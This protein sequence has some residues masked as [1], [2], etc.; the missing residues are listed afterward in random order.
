MLAGLALSAVRSLR[1][2]RVLPPGR[3]RG[4]AVLVLLLLAVL[5]PLPASFVFAADAA[6]ILEGAGEPTLLG[7]AVILTATQLALLLVAWLF[8]LRPGALPGV[9]PLPA[10]PWLPRLGRGLLL[11]VPVWL[12]ATTVGALVALV[13]MQLG[14][15]PEPQAV[16]EAIG[17]VHP[18]IVIGSYLVLTPVAEE[19]FFRGVVLNA[20]G[21]EYGYRWALVGSS[22]LFALIHGS[23]FALVPI[24]VVGLA[25]AELYRRSGSLLTV[26]GAHAGF[27]A[28]TTALVMLVNSGLIE[29]PV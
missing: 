14:L 29:P 15:E 16:E 11:G 4:P 18:G 19:V 21:R 3:Y 12:V 22:L 24:F 2:R 17:L 23:L 25:F 1:V 6:V 20:W 27:N 7:S 10:G 9:R 8:V 5:L 28:I 13:L 26:I